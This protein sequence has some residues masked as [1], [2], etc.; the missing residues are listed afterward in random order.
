[1]SIALSTLFVMGATL[2]STILGFFREVV[3][4]QFYGTRWEMD[5]FLAAAT[6][7]TILFGVFNGALVSAL[8][9]TFSEYITHGHEVDAWA[10]CNTIINSLAI[11]LTLGAAIG[12]FAA[13]LYVPI[14]AHGFPGP[15]MGV[16]IHM[17]RTLMPS[18]I[19]VSLSGVL[20]AML[21]AYHRFRSAALTGIALN[22]VT[23]GCVV[24]LNAKFGIFALVFGT[25]WGLGAQMLVQLPAFLAIGKY[26][27][28]IDLH[29][30]GLRKMWT[31]LGPIVIGSAAGQL[32]LFFDRFF[33]STLQPGYMSGINYVTKLVNFPQQIFAA[34]I[35]TVIFPLLAAQ[36]ARENRQG[37]A[38]S[39]VTGLRL[40]NFITIPSVCALIVLAHP[41]IQTLFERGT[42]GPAA[43]ELTSSLLP[44]AAIGLVSLAANVVLTRC[45]FAC[46]ET[47][48]PVAISIITVLLNVLLS[49]LWLPTLGAKGLLLANSLSQTLQAVLL[50]GLVARL[51]RGIDWGELFTSMAKVLVA[52]LAMYASLHWID[53]L[54]VH[55]DPTL[56]SRAWY[57]FG[58]IAIGGAVFIAVSRAIGVEE[59]DLAWRTI[60]A[61]FEKHIIAPPENRDAPIA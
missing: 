12:Y 3:N 35:A 51:V 32:A 20:S 1:M 41:M 14:I 60:I 29:H 6:V 13:P 44:F 31:L 22:V 47:A 28:T 58:Q 49:M 48:I 40:V 25:F 2:A 26:R 23:I 7:P 9:P 59:L 61:K 42:F 50:L 55:T 45:C 53:A 38:R 30:P 18:I 52:S 43:T 56:A 15:Q 8:V 5:T 24:A 17:T 4:A 36:F 37:V 10:L 19:A 57:L 33:A 46:R 39:A 16:A 54:G 27:F 11:V 34:A 21:N